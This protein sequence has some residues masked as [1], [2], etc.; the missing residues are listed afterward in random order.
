MAIDRKA[1]TDIVFSGAGTIAKNPIPPTIWS[2]NNEVKDYAYDP[3]QAR[4]LLAD[5]GLANGFSAYLWAMPVQRPY[6]PNARCMAEMIQQDLA[7]I[8]VKVNVVSYE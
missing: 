2:Y 4:K 5:A 8:S 1:M 6:N 3:E 7:R